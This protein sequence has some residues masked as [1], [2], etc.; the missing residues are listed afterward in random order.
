MSLRD[1]LLTAVSGA[2]LLSAASISVLA[3]SPQIGVTAAVNPA[4]EGRPP[5]TAPRELRV[6]VNVVANERIVTTE[7]GQAQMLFLDESAFS[8][9]PNSDVVLDEFVDVRWW[10]AIVP[11]TGTYEPVWTGLGTL[12]S[13]LVVAVVVTVGGSITVKIASL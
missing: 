8:I 12:A 3:Q 7:G 4:A 13:D 9:G 11:F 6:G 10:H 2:A 1:L 5:A